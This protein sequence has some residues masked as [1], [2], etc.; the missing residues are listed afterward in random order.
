DGDAGRWAVLW[1]GPL[2]DVDVD[3]GPPVETG[4][5]AELLR[6]RAHVGER[7]V[8]RLLHHVAELAGQAQRALAR[9]EGHLDGQG[10]APDLGPGQA[11]GHADLVAL[12]LAGGPVAWDAQVRGDVVVADLDLVAAAVQDHLAGHLAA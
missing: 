2:G 11:G 7:G 1:D 4:N 6:A 5:D 8:G 12:L 3:V 9:H 10:L